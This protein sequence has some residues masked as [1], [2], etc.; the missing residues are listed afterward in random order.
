MSPV[1]PAAGRRRS[2]SGELVGVGRKREAVPFWMRDVVRVPA[3][4]VTG[5]NDAPWATAP[6]LV[7]FFTAGH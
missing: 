4:A 7:N 5:L 6:I 2:C 3:E 1:L